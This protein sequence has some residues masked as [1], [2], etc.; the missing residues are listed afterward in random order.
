MKCKILVLTILLLSLSVSSFA[1][2]SGR[3]YYLTGQ[4]LDVNNKP[5]SGAMV[6]IDNKSSDVVTDDKGM[7]KVRVNADAAQISVLNLSGALMKEEI[8]GRTVINFS[9]SEAM[10]PKEVVMQE[11]PDN[12]VVNIGYGSVQKK[13]LASSVGNIDGQNK[14]F[15][16]YHS[17]FDVIK[18][19]V[20]GVQVAGNSI[21]IRG[22]GTVNASSDPLILVDGV[23]VKVESLG[24][25]VPQTVRSISILTGSDASIYGSKAANG[26]I[27]ITL[28]GK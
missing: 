25:I 9:L 20:P 3:K 16:S 8:N 19:E 4:V 2:K 17:I 15:A 27:M 22:I 5:V 26:V 7:Y 18:G 11:N 23:E 13:D 6:L 28:M 24:A 12:E 14:K 1:L 21:T 10:P